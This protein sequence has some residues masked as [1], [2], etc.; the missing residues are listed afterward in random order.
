MILVDFNLCSCKSLK[1]LLFNSQF[2]LGKSVKL[3]GVT[4][5]VLGFDTG[6]PHLSSDIIVYRPSLHCLCHFYTNDCAMDC[7]LVDLFMV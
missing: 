4:S 3:N 1:C 5:L 6:R 2:N 7:F